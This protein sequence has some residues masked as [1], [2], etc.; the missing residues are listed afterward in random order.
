MNTH[1][2][3]HADFVQA[4][5]CRNVIRV[6]FADITH[7]KAEQK[8]V[9]AYHVGG[10]LLLDTPLIELERVYGERLV[11]THRSALVARDRLIHF[12]NER[13]SI[14]ESA[15]VLLRGLA[16]PIAVSRLRIAVVRAAVA[17]IFNHHQAGEAA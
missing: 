9:V 17:Q 5:H 16:E 12:Q 1:E 3:I 13:P 2:L 14:R 8:Y 15:Y 7:F 6:P 10:Q 4:L 11:R